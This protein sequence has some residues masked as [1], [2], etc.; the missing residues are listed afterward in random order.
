M[1]LLTTVTAM[2]DFARGVR[3][4]GRSLGLVPTMGALHAGHFS[5]VRRAKSQ[6]DCV[7]VSIFV[8]PTQFSP[9]EDFAKYPR[10]LGRDLESLQPFNVAA[11]FAPPVE[12]M[13]PA[14]FDTWVEPPEVARR[15]EGELRPRHFRG[16]ATVVVKLLN[17]VRPD[18]AYFGQ[19]DFQ[20]AVVLL[21]LVQDFNI[22]TRI[23]VCPIVRG[24]TGL[25]ESSRNTYLSADERERAAALSRSLRRAES[26]VRDG[27]TR[28]EKILAEMRKV[29]EGEAGIAVDYVAIVDPWRL[30]PV[31][32][33]AAGSVALVAA[34]LGST[35]LIDNC[36]LGP[37]ELGPEELLNI[38]LGAV[39]TP[40]AGRR[41]AGVEVEAVRR[42]IEGCRLCA[43]LSPI[44]LPPREFLA[45][46]VRQYYPDP[47]AV[48]IAVIARDSP[49]IPESFLYR[50]SERTDRFISGLYRLLGVASFAEFRSRCVLTDAIRCHSS[51]APVPSRALKFCVQ[52]LLDELG[53]F[54][55]LDT[56]VILGEDAYL[57]FQRYVL[58]RPVDEIKPFLAL[59]EP[60]SYAR[61]EMVLPAFDERRM[62]V[63]YCHHPATGYQQSRPIASLLGAP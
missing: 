54:P 41:W 4:E 56:L 53:L 55:N 15:L 20:Q 62:R 10:D 43:A 18:A 46:Y 12:E 59:L 17:I 29:L 45:K 6:C 27:E 32:Q 5:L 28:A 39:V 1:R 58:R 42:R 33:V 61:E 38:A 35:R 24:P 19:K 51:Q 48:R 14:G 31:E 22:D 52:H 40:A 8:N 30:Q 44:V 63:F 3:A 47:G 49:F 37:A 7:V 25:A 36:I 23:V 16:V 26:L 11:V 60:Q 57:Q 13:Y 34:R 21:R 9:G 50:S 2:R